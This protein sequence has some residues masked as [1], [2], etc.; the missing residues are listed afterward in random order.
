MRVALDAFDVRGTLGV[1]RERPGDEERLA[2]GDVGLQ[3]GIVDVGGE[4]DARDG[5]GT[6]GGNGRAIAHL[7]E[8][9]TGVQVTG[10]T[11]LGTPALPRD[12]G[13]VRLAVDRSADFEGRVAAEDEARERRA[14]GIHG[15][16]G[17]GFGFEPR[18]QLHHLGSR[19]R[20]TRGGFRGAH[21]GLL[22][23]ARGDRDG[24]NADGAQRRESSRRGRGEVERDGRAQGFGQDDSYAQGMSSTRSTPATHDSAPPREVEL[25]VTNIAHGGVAVAR[26]EGRVVFVAD[27]IPGERVLARI[28]DDSKDKFWRA[29]T[30]R[31]LEA[32][33]HRQAHV[34]PEA[35][36][37]RDP[38]IRPGGAEFGHITLAHQREL[39][40]SVLREALARMAKLAREVEVEALPGSADGTGWRTRVRL[41]VASDGTVG[42]FA[43]R[44]HRVIRVDSLP[45]ATEAVRE[46]APLAERYPEIGS[47]PAAK[48]RGRR[49]GPASDDAHIDVLAPSV[50]GARLIIGAQARSVIR[51]RV[52]DREFRVDD[53]GF[54]QVHE[55]APQTLTEAVQSGIVEELFD[56]KAANLDLYGGVGLLAAAVGDKFGSSVRITSVESD[57]RA[58]EHAAENLADWLGAHTVT[59]RVEQWVRSL[60]DSSAAERARLSAAT[61][62]L[63]PPRSGA[64]RAVLDALTELRPAQFVYVACDPVAFARDVATLEDAGYRLDRLRAFD[65]FPNTHHVEAVGT[66]VRV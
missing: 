9:V 21:G 65:L 51:E 35:D 42:P 37:D 41:H 43:S 63:D 57:E 45:L 11:A 10:L 64:G 5:R 28:T 4:S 47:A 55:A 12:L 46:V 49:R 38:A 14:G 25:D 62:V 17:D 54:W 22:V 26:H 2:G 36:I 3:F 56:A 32:S 19:H 27:A 53:A 24:F 29:D 48:P 30:V 34:W 13:V 31:V 20:C 33:P 6:D 52:G 1:D 59:A 50:G 8:P 23:D 58:T 66:L 39:K 18:E 7:D 60:A 61:V 44:S 16:F 40:A 15:V